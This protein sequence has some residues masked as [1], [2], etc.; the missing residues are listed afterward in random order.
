M[1]R[2]TFKGNWKQIKG[3][4]KQQWGALTDDDIAEIEGKRDVMVGKLQARYGYAKDRAESELDRFL[5]AGSGSD[6]PASPGRRDVTD[7]SRS[8][9]PR[10]G[11]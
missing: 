2:D 1:N 10:S 3:K 4:I 6:A 8:R 5:R 9:R 7:R 11:A